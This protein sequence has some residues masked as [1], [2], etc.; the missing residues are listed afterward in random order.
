MLNMPLVRALLSASGA[1]AIAGCA[2]TLTTFDSKGTLTKGVPFGTP[3]LVKIT[4]RTTYQV[5]PKNQQFSE[6][7]TPDHLVKLQFLPLGE[8]HY[9]TFSPAAFGKGEFKVEFG[10]TGTLKSVSL[11]S[12]A[13][14]GVEKVG[15][16][17]GTVLPFI[18]EKKTEEA[19]TSAQKDLTAQET[20]AK[21]CLKK[22]TE[23]VA[24]ERF[25]V[26]D[27]AKTGNK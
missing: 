14:A 21:Y 2:S 8:R 15:D 22:A 24:V 4:E 12:D 16:F 3:V 27:T 5:D 10:D 9:V 26:A 25:E 1:L 20:K 23:V 17:L 19:T 6:Y 13:T 7:C 11:N 18:T